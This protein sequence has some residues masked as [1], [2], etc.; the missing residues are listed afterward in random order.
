MRF[1]EVGL[2]EMCLAEVGIF[3]MR[4]P[5]VGVLEMHSLKPTFPGW[6]GDFERAV[7]DYGIRFSSLSQVGRGGRGGSDG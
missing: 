2:F 7:V 4:F 6:S 5:E 1:P 3:E